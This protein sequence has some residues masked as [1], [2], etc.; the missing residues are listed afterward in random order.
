MAIRLHGSARTTPRIRAELQVATGS[1][2]ALAKLYGINVKTVAKWRCRTSVQDQPMGP[3]DRGSRNLHPDQEQQV[4]ELRQRGCLSLDDLMGHLL[5]QAPK[6]S[7]S[8][9]HRCLQR[10]GISR[11]PTMQNR[12]KR[13]KFEDTAFGFVH[14]DSAE[15]KIA[16]G[17]QHM[18]VAVDW[19]TKFT[20]VGLMHSPTGSI[21][22]SQTTA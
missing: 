4:I 21:P 1:N 20:H 13:G 19:V 18:F 16:S 9:L 7:R 12:P 2:R 14:I 3:R 5:G 22:C 17:K 8:A 15:M 11:F 6:L 10:H